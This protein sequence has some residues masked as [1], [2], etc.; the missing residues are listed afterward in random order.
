MITVPRGL[1]LSLAALFSTYHVILA[2]YSLDVPAS[3]V[4]PLIA[5]T[6][7]AIATVMSLWPTSPAR[8]SLWLGFFNVAVC[9]AVPLLVGSQLDGSASD[10]GY[11]TWYVAAVGTLMT[12]TATRRRATL[13]WVGVGFLFAHT[14][15]WAGPGALAA[16]GVIGSIV[17]VVV[18][19]MLARALAKAGRD[20][21]QYGLAEREATEWQAAQE[22]HLY[23][24]Q[25]R[26]AQTIRLAAPM[27]RRII[28]EGGALT[29]AQRQECRYLEGA[30]RDE[31]RGRK[32][33]NDAVRREVMAA[34]RRG[35][36]VTLLDEGGI[37]D[38]DGADLEVV[39]NTLADAMAATTAATIIAR[40][41]A[42]GSGTAVTVVGIN[43]P[44]PR[45]SAL[46]QDSPDEEVDL[47]LEIP[48]ADHAA[49]ASTGRATRRH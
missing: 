40:T 49:G 41:A 43:S 44:D 1:I 16:M 32:L 28:V 42:D 13:A 46:G 31:I 33:L 21:R 20:A 38:L 30:I 36:M 24:R 4:P 19:V 48:R 7:Y 26:L 15:V 45:L 25:V 22:A 14:L 39:L 5:I 9:I 34:R 23:E 29:E 3:P 10:N 35:A 12:I 27:L 37:D 17:W 6:L 8:M 18:A 2:F 47:W 11:A